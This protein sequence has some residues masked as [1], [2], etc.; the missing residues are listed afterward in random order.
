M[1]EFKN[2]TYSYKTSS[3]TSFSIREVSFFCKKGSIYGLLGKNG[4]GKTTIAKLLTGLIKPDS[5]HIYINN[6]LSDE[7][8][9]GKPRKTG[10]I[11]QNPDNQIVGTTVEEDLAFGLENL[12]IAPQLMKQ[13]VL[14]IACEFGID[15]YLKRPVHYLSGGEKQ[16]L[17][18]ASVLV[19]EPEYIVFD[20]PSAHL[21][22]WARAIFWNIV[23]KLAYEKNICILMITQLS[24]EIEYFDAI[25]AF[26]S[27]KLIFNGTLDEF[28]TKAEQLQN[29]NLPESWKLEKLLAN[30][31]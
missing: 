17:S 9:S 23:K 22:P 11:F 4:S 5:G 16:L 20:E 19:T 3:D 28:R 6:E 1:I 25:L 12:N 8:K 7:M 13:K 29:I 27:G 15:K 30:E 21:D 2:V 10:L 26:D 18:I 14:D 24:Y 31:P